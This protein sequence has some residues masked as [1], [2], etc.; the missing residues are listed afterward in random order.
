MKKDGCCTALARFNSVAIC[1]A[2]CHRLIQL[3]RSLPVQ[4]LALSGTNIIASGAQDGQV[5]NLIYCG[6]EDFLM[7]VR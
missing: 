1:A 2:T 3:C 5:P 4:S 6:R 7:F